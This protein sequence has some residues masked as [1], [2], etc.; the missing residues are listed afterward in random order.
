MRVDN[1]FASKI[2]IIKL[3]LTYD[4]CVCMNFCMHA[5]Y[6]RRQ[7]LTFMPSALVSVT[8]VG[9]FHLLSVSLSKVKLMVFI[10]VHV[11]VRTVCLS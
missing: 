2:T 10:A 11:H 9:T 1:L 6:S 4:L 7:K 8:E 3:T 5:C